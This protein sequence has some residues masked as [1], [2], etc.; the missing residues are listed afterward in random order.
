M[1]RPRRIA[2]AS[3]FS[4]CP[5]EVRKMFELFQTLAISFKV[6]AEVASWSWGSQ[7][8][9]ICVI[10]AKQILDVSSSDSWS[11]FPRAV[12][13]GDR[14][15]GKSSVLEPF[16]LRCPILQSWG[17]SSVTFCLAEEGGR[18]SSLSSNQTCRMTTSFGCHP[19]IPGGGNS[20]APRL[21]L[22]P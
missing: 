15:A 10:I 9:R 5:L 11:K 13:L 4:R 20:R 22:P 3:L 8:T 17:H 12:I 7:D 2:F 19:K 1:A 21:P 16:L 6:S 18:E 14:G